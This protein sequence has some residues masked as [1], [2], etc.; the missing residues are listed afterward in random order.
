[1]A[2]TKIVVGP[3]PFSVGEEYPWLAERDEDGAV[4]TFTG[5][6]RNHNLGDSVKALTLEHYPGMTEKALAEIVDEARNRWPLGRVTV[7]HRI[8][9][10]NY[11]TRDEASSSEGYIL[12]FAF[13]QVETVVGEVSSYSE[14][15]PWLNGG[16]AYYEFLEKQKSDNYTVRA[17]L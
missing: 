9:H 3:Q 8:F 15:T 5:K 4:V 10:G 11:W 6:V 14:F 16:T 2:E 7:I 1:M 13:S 12:H 17:I